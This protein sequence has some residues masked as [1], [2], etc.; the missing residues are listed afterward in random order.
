LAED[1][2][3][4]YAVDGPNDENLNKIKEYLL[5]SHKEN[6]KEN[7]Y[8][9]NVL[10]EKYWTGVDLDTEYEKILNDITKDDIRNFTRYILKQNNI[11]SIL[12]TG[13]GE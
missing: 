8:W 7:S 5:K 6:L 1:I 11:K 3:N 10:S 2:F 12:M 4:K 13:I 9:L